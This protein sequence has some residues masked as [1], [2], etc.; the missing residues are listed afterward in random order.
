VKGAPWVVLAIMFQ[1][2]VL[3]FELLQAERLLTRIALFYLAM[4]LA[5]VSRQ[6][7]LPIFSAICSVAI[8]ANRL[9]F[10]GRTAWC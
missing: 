10:V 6:V 8:R 4:L 3:P 9:T 2:G 7:T 5:P 1:P